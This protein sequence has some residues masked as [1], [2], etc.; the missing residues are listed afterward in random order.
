MVLELLVA[1]T[2]RLS[3]PMPASTLR[4]PVLVVFTTG[5][6]APAWAVVVLAPV[7]VTLSAS[8]PEVPARVM[9]PAPALRL[10]VPIPGKATVPSPPPDTLAVTEPRLAVTGLPLP[11]RLATPAPP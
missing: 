11:F 7:G 4:V 9:L 3:L 8:R 6:R 5:D 1:L 10:R 2:V